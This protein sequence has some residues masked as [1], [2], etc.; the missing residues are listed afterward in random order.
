MP[1]PC[2][3][4]SKTTTDR[5]WSYSYTTYYT[6]YVNKIMIVVKSR[7]GFKKRFLF[8][9]QYYFIYMITL[10]VITKSKFV[11]CIYVIK[12]YRSSIIH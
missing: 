12:A 9:I 5:T 11:H 10:S 6:R 1:D 7:N 4:N 2:F 8:C 3:I